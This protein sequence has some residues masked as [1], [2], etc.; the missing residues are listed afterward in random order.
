MFSLES[1]TL[2]TCALWLQHRR[3]DCCMDTTKPS[4]MRREKLK[5]RL[6]SEILR[7]KMS[8]QKFEA[9][10]VERK[11]N[12]STSKEEKLKVESGTKPVESE[13]KSFGVMAQPDRKDTHQQ[14]ESTCCGKLTSIEDCTKK[15]HR[16]ASRGSNQKSTVLMQVSTIQKVVQMIDKEKNLSKHSVPSNCV[17]YRVPP[18]AERRIEFIM[19]NKSDE[20]SDCNA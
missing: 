10:L 16:S 1:T 11:G 8:L 19:R 2:T 7:S 18:D 14:L 13:T 12:I 17:S 5:E 9:K 20:N 6:K 15:T 4:S 3:N